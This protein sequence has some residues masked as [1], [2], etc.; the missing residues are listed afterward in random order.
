MSFAL[1]IATTSAFLGQAK[2]LPTA[3]RSLPILAIP[4]LLVTATLL[5]WLAKLAWQRRRQRHGRISG[6]VS[7]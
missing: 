7:A 4:V 5:Y 6:A 1:W 2:F 3:V